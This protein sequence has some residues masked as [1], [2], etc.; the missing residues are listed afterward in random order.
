MHNLNLM[1]KRLRYQGGVE[2]ENRM[3]RDKLHSL[4]GALLYSYQSET[5]TKGDNT[6][7]A[8][9]NSNKLNQSYDEKLLS[10]EYNKEV[11]V[12][13]VIYW[14][15]AQSYWLVY[16]QELTETAY[17]LGH[18][19]RCSEFV[20]DE[21]ENS[22]L[23]NLRVVAIGPNGTSLENIKKNNFSIDVPNLMIE[24]WIAN[25][26][27]NKQAFQRYTKFKLNDTTWEVQSINNIDIPNIL[28]ITAKETYQIL[29][30]EQVKDNDSDV[31]VSSL[32]SGPEEIKPRQTHTYTYLGEE[33]ADWD[34]EGKSLEILAKTATQITV[35]W[36]SSK[37]GSFTLKYGNEV[38]PVKVA[39]LF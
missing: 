30:D 22:S 38:K 29:P 26:E 19:R 10:C 33:N 21:I 4:K 37:S 16:M 12:G 23:K 15:E 11:A 34:W 9:I 20:I 13:D 8:L 25:T 3:V 39:S 24:V 14:E 32:I 28:I 7:K 1:E 36:D 31:E 35:R 5:V 17:F 6:F 2:Q 27:E 18:M